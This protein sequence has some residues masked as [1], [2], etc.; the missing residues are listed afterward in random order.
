MRYVLSPTSGLKDSTA[1][2]AF[3]IAPAMNPRTVCFC[4][5]ILSII[6]AR[7]APLFRCTRA[8]TWAVFVPSRGAALSCA[9]AAF[10]ALGAF[11]VAVAFLIALAFAGA[12]LAVR[13][14]A[15]GFLS[16]FGFAGSASGLAASLNP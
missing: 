8:I 1:Y 9:L 16:A 14:P 10:L 6:S 5:F 15:L 2:P 12:P 7:V 13:A 3:F 4:Q 11:L